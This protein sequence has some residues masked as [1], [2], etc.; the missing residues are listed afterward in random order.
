MP[1]QIQSDQDNANLNKRNLFTTTASGSTVGLVPSG[2]KN[3][4]NTPA[5]QQESLQETLEEM[6]VMSKVA[7]S[8]QALQQG[9]GTYFVDFD[10]PASAGILK[11]V[12]AS[13]TITNTNGSSAQVWECPV[14]PFAFN[15]IQIMQNGTQVGRDILPIM[16]W[17]WYAYVSSLNE[18]Q[19]LQY[20]T[21][22]SSSTYA[23]QSSQNLA[24]NASRTFCLDIAPL[25]GICQADV[26]M[27]LCNTVTI[28][29][30]FDSI[31]TLAPSNTNSVNAAQNVTD[32][33]L[34]VTQK[35][36]SHVDEDR[37]KA[38]YAVGHVMLVLFKLKSI[39]VRLL[40]LVLDKFHTFHKC[41][42]TTWLH[43]PTSV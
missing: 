38:Q 3:I 43:M 32:F 34:I 7:V 26:L 22:I 37:L 17:K 15:K 12:N 5:K 21:T 8:S 27:K 24:A 29:F 20:R 4:Y 36:L 40:R 39:M 6:V 33:H 30:Y 13:L 14:L 9:A 10:M 28:R 11:N 1:N 25:L 42:I 18:M 16:L 31:S 23:L 41:L 35:S 2:Y 19:N